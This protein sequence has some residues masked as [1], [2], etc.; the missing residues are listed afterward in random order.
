MNH[1]G[2]KELHTN[3]LILRKFRLEDGEAMYQNWASD[4]H[5]TRF[6]TWPTHPNADVTRMLLGYWVKN[7]EKQDYYNWGI[8]LKE[9]GELIGN[10]SVVQINEEISAATLGYCMGRKWWGKGIM[11]EA[12]KAVIRY[13][14]EEAGFNRIAATHDK[15]NPNSGRVM[16]KIG[17]RY[18]GTLRAAGKNNQGVVD[19]VWYGVLKDEY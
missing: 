18:E 9:T 19:E 16:Q 13:L 5:V 4:D 2:T 3:R 6:L 15:N 10:I 17:M 7:Y 14:F 11:P 8:E 12:G 1:C